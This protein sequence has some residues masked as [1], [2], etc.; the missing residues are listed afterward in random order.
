MEIR[1]ATAGSPDRTVNEDYAFVAGGLVGVLDGVTELPGTDSGCAHGPAWYVRRLAAHLAD[2]NAADLGAPLAQIL[3]TAIE[4]VRDEHS[5][6]CD[7]SRP[8]TPAAAVGLFR[9]AGDQA[10]YL[11]LCDVSLV[12]DNGS[13][14]T[15]ITD[16]RLSTIMADVR[17]SVLVPGAT[18]TRE[19]TARMGRSTNEKYSYINRSGGYWIAAADPA[20]AFEAVTGTIP[21]HGPGRLCRAAL[22]TDGASSAVDLYKMLDW[23]AVLDFLTDNGPAALIDRIREVERADWNGRDNPRYKRHDDATIALCLFDREQP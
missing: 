1:L 18:G 21:L 11:M 19:Q 6:T 15:V 2:A 4:R 8:G 14:P 13:G 12:L 16:T 7:L 23:L 5:A 9:N 10:E 22:L 17:S 3:S 20:A